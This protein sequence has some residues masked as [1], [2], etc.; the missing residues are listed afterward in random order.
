MHLVSTVVDFSFPVNPHSCV[1]SVTV[2]QT[3]TIQGGTGLFADAT[4][5]F[6]ARRPGVGL[7]PCNPDGGCCLEQPARHEVD[8]ITASGTPSL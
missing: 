4:G 7:R 3:G 6:T 2:Q 8:K 5:S 1:V